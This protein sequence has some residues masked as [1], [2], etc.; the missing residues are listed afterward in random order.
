MTA[1]ATP[2]SYPFEPVIAASK[3]LLY[4]VR[5][6]GATAFL[7]L[8]GRFVCILF[9]SRGIE[10]ENQGIRQCLHWLM[11]ATCVACGHDSNLPET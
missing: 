7:E 1:A 3:Q 9:F 4:G 2:V 5:P 6:D 8:L 10:K 11:Q